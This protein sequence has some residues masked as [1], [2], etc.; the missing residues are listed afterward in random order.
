MKVTVLIAVLANVLLGCSNFKPN[1]SD[2]FLAINGVRLYYKMEGSHGPPL[3]L[4]HGGFG[5]T[6]D[7]NAVIKPLA[8]HFSVIAV[9]SPGHGKSAQADSLSYELMAFYISNL[10]DHLQLDSLYVLGWSDGGNTA[11][12]LASQLQDKIKRVMVCG[13]NAN[14]QGYTEEVTIFLDQLSPEFA[15]S[16]MQDWLSDYL[17]NSPDPEQWKKYV[18]DVKKMWLQETVVSDEKLGTIRQPALIVLGDRDLTRLEHGIH[19]YR[20]MP[21][22]QYC[23]LPNTSHFMF[24]ERPRQLVNLAHDFFNIQ[25]KTVVYE[26]GNVD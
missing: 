11:L 23:V 25:K 7:F 19:M 4:L 3:L 18:E 13:A 6:N 14:I 10:I 5:S 1:S 20:T 17:K 2:H 8:N 21:N 12:L 22:A 26:S 16:E 24:R 9:D 15:T